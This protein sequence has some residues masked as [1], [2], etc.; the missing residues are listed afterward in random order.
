MKTNIEPTYSIAA[1]LCLSSLQT[2][3]MCG[4][5]ISGNWVMPDVRSV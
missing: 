1:I 4:F 3:I 2:Y 5:F